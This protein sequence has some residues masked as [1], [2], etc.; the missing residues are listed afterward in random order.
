MDFHIGPVQVH[1]YGIGLAI[2]FWFAYSYYLRRLRARDL[3]YEWLQSGFLWIIAAAI[4]GAR[5]VHVAAN[6]TYYAEYPGQIP[7][8]WHGGL[9]S[10]GGLF[11]GA[12]V[13]IYFLRRARPKLAVLTALDIITPVLMAAWSMGRLLGPQLMY[14]GGGRVTHAWYGLQYAGQT[15]YRIPVPLFQSVEDFLIFLVLIWVERRFSTKNLPAGW[16]LLTGLSLWSVER[17]F[18]EFLWLAVPRLWDAVE[19]FSILLFVVSVASLFI[20]LRRS[21]VALAEAETAPNPTTDQLHG[22]KSLKP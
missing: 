13:G 14:A 7:L 20:L 5:A 15:G 19:V 22:E 1:T 4:V 6:I 16:L 12:V 9:S 21:R 2:T 17:F 3:P 10:F 8:V 18:D 11:G